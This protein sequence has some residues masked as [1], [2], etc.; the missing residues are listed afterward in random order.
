MIVAFEA[1]VPSTNNHMWADKKIRG[2]P[3]PSIICPVCGQRIDYYAI[4]PNYLPPRSY[5]DLSRCFDGDFLVSPRFRDF[6][7]SQ[8]LTGIGFQQIQ[9]SRRYFVLKCTNI[10]ELVPPDTLHKKEFCEHCK[11]YKSVWGLNTIDEPVKLFFRGVSA[12]IPQGIYLT[13]LKAGYGPLFGPLLLFGV[14]TWQSILS[15][16]FK[17]IYGT[18]IHN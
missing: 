16:K 3:S 10:L 5:N 11:Q 2:T 8:G 15:Q 9:R 4:N 17:G 13:D 6:I 7:E 14:D 1:S 18:A 12:P